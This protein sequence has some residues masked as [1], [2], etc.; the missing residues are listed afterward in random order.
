M[1]AIGLANSVFLAA[2]THVKTGNYYYY[3]QTHSTTRRLASGRP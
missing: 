2:E 1:F 3:A